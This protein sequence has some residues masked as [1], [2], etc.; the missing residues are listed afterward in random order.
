MA[1]NGGH[2]GRGDGTR[3][4]PCQHWPENYIIRYQGVSGRGDVAIYGYFE[5]KWLEGKSYFFK[6]LKKLISLY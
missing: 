4:M 5:R 6:G 2:V 3:G 1:A